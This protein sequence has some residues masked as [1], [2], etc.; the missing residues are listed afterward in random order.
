MK[1]THLA[2]L[3][4]L[5]LSF[6]A[7]ATIL[8]NEFVWDDS[9]FIQNAPETRTFSR[10]TESFGEDV[11]QIY[12]PIRTLAYFA[13]YKL[14][15]LN[16]WAYHLFAILLHA[17]VCFLLYLVIRKLF[18]EP[19]ALL[20]SVLFAVH[21][22]NVGRVANA[23]ASFDLIG[24]IFYLLAF[25]SYLRF[26][27]ASARKFLLLSIGLFI[28]GLFSSEEVY[29]LPLLI[30]VYEF[31]FQER[32]ITSY[33][34]SAIYLAL[35]GAFL[36]LRMGILHIGARISTYAGGSAW[37][38]FLS[39]PLALW[40][41][42]SF[43]F[44]PIGLSP[45]RAIHLVQSA[46]AIGF[47]LPLLG[48]FLIGYVVYR[49]RSKKEVLFWAGWLGVTM[50]PF[51]NLSPLPQLMA[52]RYFYLP[53]VALIFGISSLLLALKPK[54]IVIPIVLVLLLS[55][56]WWQA[57]Y[58]QNDLTLMSRGV[59]LNPENSQAL[60]NLGTWYFNLQQYE[61]AHRYFLASVKADEENHRAWVNLGVLYS[62][63]GNA[64][65]SVLA[66]EQAIRLTPG[67]YN[68][69]EKL[70]ITYM[71]MNETE[72]AEQALLISIQL[73]PTYYRSYATLGSLYGNLGKYDLALPY[74]EKS[75]ALNPTY[76]ESYFNLG[77][78][79]DRAGQSA[80]A[81]EFYRK[82]YSLE[83]KPYY[84]QRIK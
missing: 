59:E 42:A 38:T 78:L 11:F 39:M 5:L 13:A 70:G 22:N 20:T 50:L 7:Y 15:G 56:T 66:L 25:Y 19:A 4:L 3:G 84:Q 44:Y 34:T 81:Q 77:I 41:Y 83:P 57:S 49:F 10:A 60:N 63:T 28:L 72:K 26:R 54:K 48:L 65:Q 1:R 55:L 31:V 75:I 80:K 46:A 64:N 14:F 61:S 2:A 32:K 36:F 69:Y 18:S 30:L 82:A 8:N 37:V 74:L 35:L 27:E 45:F 16:P 52:E 29:T 62:T 6:L 12:R 43:I 68:A 58:W 76:A 53:S 17:G 79:Y 21:P 71:R 73:E 67:N 9:R 51:L 23:T 40:T 33:K 47:W 24:I